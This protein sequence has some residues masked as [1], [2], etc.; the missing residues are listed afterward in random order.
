MF[1]LFGRL[2]RPSVMVTTVVLYDTVFCGCL[3]LPFSVNS[4]RLLLDQLS[5]QTVIDPI[6]EASSI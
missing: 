4:D 5:L 3:G 1:V 2:R 6:I